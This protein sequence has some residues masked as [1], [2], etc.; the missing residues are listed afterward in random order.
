MKLA[1]RRRGVLDCA[2][3][4]SL[5]EV[6]SS[7]LVNDALMLTESMK[8]S[9]NNAILDAHKDYCVERAKEIDTIRSNNSP[10]SLLAG[11]PIS[12]KDNINVKDSKTTAGS[13][14]LENFRSIY[15]ATVIQR[16]KGSHAIP[17]FKANM[18]EFGMGSSLLNSAFGQCFNPQIPFSSPPLSPGGSS[19]GSAAAVASGIVPAAIASDTGGSIRLPASFCGLVG[20]KPTYGSVSRFGLISYASSMDTIGVITNNVIDS[21]IILDVISG[22][23]KNDA[24][25]IHDMPFKMKKSLS[26]TTSLLKALN[27]KWDK[28]TYDKTL[29]VPA[30]SVPAFTA[31]EIRQMIECQSNLISLKGFKVGVPEEFIIH[32]LPGGIRLA[33]EAA[34]SMLQDA[35]ASIISV[36]IPTL[37]QALPAYYVLACSEAASNLS[38]YDGIRYGHRINQVNASSS[39]DSSVM[40]DMLN[41][42]ASTRRTGFGK[43]VIKRILTGTYVLTASAYDQYYNK[44]ASIRQKISNEI[45]NCYKDEGVNIMIFPTAPT[46]PYRLDDPPDHSTSICND[47]YTV[48]SNL[49]GLPAVN[50]PVNMSGGDNIKSIGIQLMG[51]ILGETDVLTAALALEQRTSQI[52]AT[53]K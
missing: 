4:L 15:D 11:I 12:I 31:D 25:M 36:S 35:G 24:T 26:V 2:L 50:V 6:S 3:S 51:N 53:E 1:G 44:A 9:G 21:A 14:M 7:K 47:F 13:K 27:C 43:E 38:R 17:G 33:W 30:T 19:G 40:N 46:L 16:L 28:S 39:K 23:D 41:E 48:V 10:L 29:L 5:G 52:K 45:S 32:E 22:Y 37:K 34:I 20:L 8:V 42:V 18:D 49:T